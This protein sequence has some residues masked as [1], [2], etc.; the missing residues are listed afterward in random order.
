MEKPREDQPTGFTGGRLRGGT[1]D[2][3]GF[4]N[5]VSRDR[6]EVSLLGDSMI[7]GQGVDIDETV[8]HYLESEMG[9]SVVNLAR[10]GD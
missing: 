4:R 6:A 10:Q 9:K 3:R 2:R 7:Y 8:G 1:V 5:A